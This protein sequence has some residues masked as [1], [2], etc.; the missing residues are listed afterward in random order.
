MSI[1]RALH[2]P[3]ADLDNAAR[4]DKAA[5]TVQCLYPIT[6]GQRACYLVG[7]LSGPKRGGKVSISKSVLETT[8][9]ALC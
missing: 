7:T 3:V 1:Q 9:N 2:P 4:A 5:Q 8:D 6:V